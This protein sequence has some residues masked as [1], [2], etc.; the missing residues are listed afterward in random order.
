[1][2]EY[3]YLHIREKRDD[4]K[5]FAPDLTVD[6]DLPSFDCGQSSGKAGKR[7]TAMKMR[8]VRHNFG[9]TPSSNTTPGAFGR[10]R[11]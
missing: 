7:S 5:D 6:L 8:S 10:E 1:M 9:P 11:K 4:P 2:T 3:Q